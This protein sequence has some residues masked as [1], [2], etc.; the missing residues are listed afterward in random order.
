[1]AVRTQQPQV[2]RRV[3]GVVAIDVVELK[4]HASRGGL[5]LLPA[6]ARAAFAAQLDQ[7]AAD[8]TRD[9]ADATAADEPS[10]PARD[11]RAVLRAMLTRVR[12]VLGAGPADGTLTAEAGP[13]DGHARR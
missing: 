8:V 9:F 5:S 12:A 2:A 7:I 3:V 13:A 11:E 4:W 1:M 6:A 10:Q